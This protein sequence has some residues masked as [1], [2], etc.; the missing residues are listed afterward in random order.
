[1]L[2]LA[3]ERTAGPVV[4]A[5]GL[6]VPLITSPGINV[7]DNTIKKKKKILRFS[8]MFFFVFIYFFNKYYKNVVIFIL[9]ICFFGKRLLLCSETRNVAMCSIG[10][11]KS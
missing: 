10:R 11:Q 9:C 8:F 2:N 4:G 6:L 3:T 5:G 7:E 1:L